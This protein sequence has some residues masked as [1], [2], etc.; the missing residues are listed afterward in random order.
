[1]HIFYDNERDYAEVFFS[2]EENYGELLEAL[3]NTTMVFKSELD[4]RIIGYGFEEASRTLFASDFLSSSAKLA[5]LLKMIRA[6][7]A[8]TQEQ[9]IQKV[10]NLTLRHYQRLE[11]GDENPTLGT[12]ENLMVAFPDT[13]F[14]QILKKSA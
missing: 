3:D 1:M 11:T 9:V 12:I 6:Q 8:L 10:G 2:K 4:D 5:A 14:S 13:D 7:K